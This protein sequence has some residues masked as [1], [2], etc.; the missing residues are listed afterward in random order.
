MLTYID[1]RQY[2]A[3]PK[4]VVHVFNFTML[5]LSW[6]C[7]LCY[8]YVNTVFSLHGW[9]DNLRI[10]VSFNWQFRW[11]WAF[12]LYCGI[13]YHSFSW[14]LLIYLRE[15]QKSHLLAYT[16]HVPSVAPW[17]RLSQPGARNLIQVSWLGNWYLTTWTITCRLPGCWDW[18]QSQGLNPGHSNMGYGRPNQYLNHQAKCPKLLL[19]FDCHFVQQFTKPCN[20]LIK[21]II[22][23]CQTS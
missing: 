15:T 17:L 22:S 19:N 12:N 23:R 3:G 5:Y 6:S 10:S 9:K 20:H 21:Y 14:H 7:H 2:V 1:S 4:S 18:E 13:G 8:V 16:P 11:S